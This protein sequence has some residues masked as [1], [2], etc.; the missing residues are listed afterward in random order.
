M[1][2][3]WRTDEEDDPTDDD[4]GDGAEEDDEDKDSVGKCT[5]G[6]ESFVISLI[7]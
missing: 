5:A 4:E 6:N 7:G 2:G 3:C 1:S